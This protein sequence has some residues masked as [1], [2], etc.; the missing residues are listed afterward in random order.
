MQINYCSL[1]SGHLNLKPCKPN[2]EWA[3]S[4]CIVNYQDFEIEWNKYLVTIIQ[5]G[6]RLEN[7]LN[8]ENTLGSLNYRISDVIMQFQ[9]NKIVITDKVFEKCNDNKFK[10]INKRSIRKIDDED[11][12]LLSVNKFKETHAKNQEITKTW[13][14]L[15]TDVK[16]KIKTL[17]SYWSKLPKAICKNTNLP[18]E[19]NK[20]WNGTNSIDL[21][22]QIKPSFDIRIQKNSNIYKLIDSYKNKL[23]IVN[24]KL[25]SSYNGNGLEKFDFDAEASFPIGITTDLN[26]DDNED[27]D[28]EDS[29]YDDNKN[30]RELD[31]Q[32]IPDDE[33]IEKNLEPQDDNDGIESKNDNVKRNQND[34]ENNIYSDSV[35]LDKPKDASLTNNKSFIINISIYT[36]IISQL[37]LVSFHNRF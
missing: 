5:F 20:C 14:R 21:N 15:A 26:E 3:Y 18:T 1:C 11:D 19:I 34:L 12:E 37:I 16:K 13:K 8:L 29:D 7:T 17:K 2:C 31:Q 6:R 22:K 27:D 24:N 33:P 23:Q 9:E 25:I 28:E 30:N 35:N 10:N 32:Q 4:K 36:L